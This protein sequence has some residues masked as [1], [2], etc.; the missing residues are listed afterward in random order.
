MEKHTDSNDHLNTGT[1]KEDGWGHFL[2]FF[3]C[4]LNIISVSEITLMLSIQR[5]NAAQATGTQP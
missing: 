5:H 3:F 1:E 2:F 4:F